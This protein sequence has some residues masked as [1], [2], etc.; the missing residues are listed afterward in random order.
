MSVAVISPK[1]EAA[2]S[3]IAAMEEGECH[4][5]HNVSWGEYEELLAELGE[6]YAVRVAYTEGELELMSP[7]Y[8]HEKYKDLINAMVRVL[9]MEMGLEME[10]A[11]S[12]TL[13]IKRVRRGAEPDTCF[14]I[15]NAAHL[16]G[17]EH[18]DLQFDP[19]PD[20]VFEVDVTSKSTSK[21]KTYARFGV[22]E[23]WRYDGKTFRIYELLGASYGERDTSLTFAFLHASDLKAFLER[24]KMIGQNALLA[25]FEAWVKERIKNE[26]K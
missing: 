22:P 15:Q 3:L 25:E 20:I 5:I 1:V 10:S 26:G 2:L 8:R 14:Y 19:P 18:I 24:S 13:K 6:G 11:G 23:L 12:T 9:T 21:M 4:V 16:I 7:L 17:R